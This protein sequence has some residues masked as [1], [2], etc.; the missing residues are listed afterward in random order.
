MK[1]QGG[2]ETGQLLYQNASDA[3]LV[4]VR[5]QHP[6]CSLSINAIEQSRVNLQRKDELA[7]PVHQAMLSALL[8]GPPPGKVLLA[9]LGGGALPRYLA[10]VMPQC[11]G[12]AVELSAE[13]AGLCQQFF[14]FP[15][16]RWRLY[17]MDVMQWRGAGYDWLL[18]DIAEDDVTPSWLTSASSLQ[19]FKQQLAPTGLLVMN[20]LVNDVNQLSTV[21]MTMRKLF[22]RRTLCLTVPGY[23]NIVVMAFNQATS[24]FSLGQLQQRCSRLSE[25][26]NIDFDRLL[27]Q[28]LKD[29]PPDNGVIVMEPAQTGSV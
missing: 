24:S 4:E 8:F 26:Y 14:D 29:N 18:V 1:T 13:V 6:Y 22:Q 17:T 11:E 19:H 12:D 2:S 15:Q 5:L 7:L 28:L 23:K 25:Q 16:A 21:L 3:G 9:G 20:L 10:H 27:Q